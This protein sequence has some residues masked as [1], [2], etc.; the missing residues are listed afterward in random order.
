MGH[1][2]GASRF[3]ILPG[4]GLSQRWLGAKR[5]RGHSLREGKTR[6]R[7]SEA[8]KTGTHMPGPSNVG[9]R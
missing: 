6:V 4:Q 5:A 9:L 2:W 8:E 7:D 3:S 1:Q